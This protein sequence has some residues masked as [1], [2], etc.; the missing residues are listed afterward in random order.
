MTLLQWFFWTLVKL[1][2]QASSLNSEWLTPLLTNL[3]LKIVITTRSLAA[4]GPLFATEYSK[5]LLPDSSTV[6][7]MWSLRPLKST[8]M[9]TSK[10]LSWK[11]KY[12]LTTFFYNVVA[13]TFPSTTYT[14]FITLLLNWTWYPH[15]GWSQ[16]LSPPLQHSLGR[17]VSNLCSTKITCHCQ[18]S[19]GQKLRHAQPN[20]PLKYTSYSLQQH[21]SC[22][23]CWR[24]HYSGSHFSRILLFYSLKNVFHIHLQTWF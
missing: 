22:W 20:L 18:A 17:S 13:L 15:W 10:L 11:P 2:L 9:P 7:M 21:C 8:R 5:M 4:H 23:L 19:Q 12:N 3:T 24:S 1:V 6:H 14:W 16:I